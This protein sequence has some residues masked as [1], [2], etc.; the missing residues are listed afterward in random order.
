[1][2]LPASLLVPKVQP[3]NCVQ[4][5]ALFEKQARL[6]IYER[7]PETLEH[8]KV[9][10]IIGNQGA[11]VCTLHVEFGHVRPAL[12]AHIEFFALAHN[13][14][15]AV[16]ATEHVDELVPKI[17]VCGERCAAVPDVRHALESAVSEMENKC[18]IYG[19][20]RI[21]TDMLARNNEKF[22]IRHVQRPAEL[23]LLI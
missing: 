4:S 13:V 17:V 7:V 18:V 15:I 20:T 1:M 5:L 10:A 3:F 9:S 2:D 23:Y 6:I 11:W 16:I 12:A 8:V 14:T 21:F 19:L 22:L